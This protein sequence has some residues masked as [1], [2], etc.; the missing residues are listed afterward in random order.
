MP[1]RDVQDIDYDTRT[2]MTQAFEAVCERL[3]LAPDDTE[4]SEVAFK[5]IELVSRG[6]K[7]PGKLFALALE[8]FNDM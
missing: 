5:I 3:K 4:R 8:P 1:F 7:D 2:N 6:E